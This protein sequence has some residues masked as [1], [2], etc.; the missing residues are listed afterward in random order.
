[1]TYPGLD[2]D[3]GADTDQEPVK[4]TVWP[5]PPAARLPKGPAPTSRRGGAGPLTLFQQTREALARPPS[6]R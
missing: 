5:C 2:T 3:Y 1:M 4:T 6:A